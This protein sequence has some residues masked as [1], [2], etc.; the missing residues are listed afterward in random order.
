MCGGYIC[1]AP[2]EF[3]LLHLTPRFFTMQLSSIL[4]FS[5][6]LFL[7]LHTA[8]CSPVHPENVVGRTLQN[9]NFTVSSDNTGSLLN[10]TINGYQEEWPIHRTSMVLYLRRESRTALKLS[11]AF[12]LLNEIA[13]IADARD[14]SEVL[15][16]LFEYELNDDGPLFAIGPPA[17][18]KRLTW[19]DVSKIVG[20][21]VQYFVNVLGNRKWCPE[22]SFEIGDMERGGIGYGMVMKGRKNKIFASGVNDN[23]TATS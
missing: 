17:K 6:V 18:L 2:L 4:S 3:A 9:S 1:L 19:G 12:I 10:T 22:L 11:L 16:R 23:V 5:L 8:L 15:D 14:P 13:S 7:Q 20:G 21:L